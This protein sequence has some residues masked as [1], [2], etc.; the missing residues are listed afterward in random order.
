MIGVDTLEHAETYDSWKVN[1]G[2]EEDNPT[3][4]T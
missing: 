2:R 4:K 3:I 1:G